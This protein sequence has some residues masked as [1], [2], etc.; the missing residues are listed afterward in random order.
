[1]TA[2]IKLLKRKNFDKLKIIKSPTKEE[3]Q[4]N[5]VESVK[6]GSLVITDDAMYY[7]SLDKRF[8]HKSLH[9]ATN[10]Y[11]DEGLT[12]NGFESVWALMKRGYKGVYHHW[13]KSICQDIWMN[14]P[15]D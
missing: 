12:T 8:K 14:L 3:L 9:H 7:H 15:L 5:I 10:Q 2:V 11:V 1:V 4:G 6:E 13:S